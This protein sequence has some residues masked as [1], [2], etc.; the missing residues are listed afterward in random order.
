MAAWYLFGH[1]LSCI[2]KNLNSRWGDID[3][4]M[5]EKEH[6]TDGDSK[7]FRNKRV[8]HGETSR[9]NAILIFVEVRNRRNDRCG[10]PAE[11]VD[12]R[13]QAKILRTANAYLARHTEYANLPVRFDVVAVTQRNCKPK[14]LMIR[15]AFR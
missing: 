14:I 9:G 4:V 2:E 12:Q 5:L 15:D 6:S 13:K 1:G 8:S 10:S 3:L 7:T 11:S